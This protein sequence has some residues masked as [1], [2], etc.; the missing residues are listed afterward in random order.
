MPSYTETGTSLFKERS[1]EWVQLSL[2]IAELEEPLAVLTQ[3]LG[4]LDADLSTE[5]PR[6]MAV[7][8]SQQPTPEAAG[9]ALMDHSAF[10]VL[11]VFGTYELIRTLDQ[12]LRAMGRE[13]LVAELRES[14]LLLERVRIPLAK[15]E[16]A[17]RH[18]ATDAP[19]PGM[20]VHRE[21]GV[22]WRVAPDT[23]IPRDQLSVTV[24]RA[25]SSVTAKLRQE[26][27]AQPPA[28]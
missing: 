17:R 23:L 25:L 27:P 10:A 22:G 16:P 4:R 20:A 1:R 15:V 5:A 28:S 21:L 26:G 12:R 13:D 6:V 18:E 8:R 3:Q 11:W 14:K 9:M 24:R 7:H 19:W 2:R